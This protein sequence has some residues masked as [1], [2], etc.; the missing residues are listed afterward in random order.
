MK[1]FHSKSS[2]LLFHVIETRD[3]IYIEELMCLHSCTMSNKMSHPAQ[4]PCGRLAQAKAKQDKCKS[5][6]EGQKP[7]VCSSKSHL[8]LMVIAQPKTEEKCLVVNSFFVA[9]SS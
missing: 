9:N 1:V 2:L 3:K 5:E 7:A 8:I 4:C 6:R